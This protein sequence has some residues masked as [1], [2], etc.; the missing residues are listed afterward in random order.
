MPIDVVEITK[1]KRWLLRAAWREFGASSLFNGAWG[2]LAPE[3][4]A[5][6]LDV[7]YDDNQGQIKNVRRYVPLPAS[8]RRLVA[9]HGTTHAGLALDKLVYR[10]SGQEL[11][12]PSLHQVVEVNNG[13]ADDQKFLS[14]TYQPL[15]NRWRTVW[16]MNAAA[17]FT[18][19]TVGPLALHLSRASALENAGICLHPLYGFA[20]LPGS[21]LKGMARAYAETI[22]LPEQPDKNAAWRQIE[23]VFGWA[24]NPDRGKQLKDPS[25]PARPRP[26]NDADPRSPEI[27]SSS[28]QIIF[29]DAWP[30]AWPKLI[31]DIVNNH[32]S[33]YY[34]AKNDNGPGD[35]EGPIPVYFLAVSPGEQ[36]E[37]ALSKRRGDVSQP[38]LN[39][40]ESWLTG[41]LTQL[42]AGAKTAAG[43][44]AF[45]VAGTLRVPS[46][47]ASSKSPSTKS[48]EAT[49][50]VVTPAFLAGASQNA[51]D[52]DLRGATLRGLLRWWWRTM[53][54]G[55][56]DVATLRRLEA[57]VWGDTT[58]G[59]TIR[60]AVEPC[61]KRSPFERPGKKPGKDRHGKEIL[62]NDDDFLR[63]HAISTTTQGLFYAGYGTDELVPTGGKKRRKR[64]WCLGE[65]SKWI[66]RLTTK[67]NCISV[68]EHG[69]PVRCGVLP[70]TLI[71]DQCLAAL[72]LFCQYGGA[73]AKSRKGFGSFKSP[74]ELNDWDIERVRR[75]AEEFRAHWKIARLP[76]QSGA[77]GT[78]C[79]QAA[80]F[81]EQATSWTDSWF[82]I[83]NL[84]QWMQ[85]FAQAP[86]STGHGKH[87]AGKAA[88][89]LPRKIHGPLSGK[90]LKHQTNHQDPVPLRAP[91]GDRHASPVFYHF[92]RG[93]GGSLIFRAVIFHT[94]HLWDANKTAQ[95][96]REESQRVLKALA[97]HL[98]HELSKVAQAAGSTASS[99][100]P[101]LAPA[102]ATPS[103]WEKLDAVYIQRSGDGHLVRLLDGKKAKV[104]KGH[105]P[106]PL[107]KRDE[108]VHVYR[109]RSNARE[110]RWDLPSAR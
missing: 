49:L 73:G 18:A 2:K 61:G 24:P 21:G 74:P 10:Y 67:P 7:E 80:E 35:W 57:A 70:P 41:A 110:Y 46:A 60:L 59:S 4:V 54:A 53:H 43:Y 79:L 109:Q 93:A 99:T 63:K 66:L 26:V 76:F 42:G 15:F 107:P 37:F 17:H 32:H 78:A 72:W 48:F 34:G 23:D 103:D 84:G 83:D 47:A 92:A 13:L 106:V 3:D 85:S 62:I 81:I 95:L 56:V 28:G 64:R 11:S 75:V 91:H 102:A 45:K 1:D 98:K 105:I 87:C 39:L 44:G 22:W 50:E 14:D 89:G 65:G 8:T 25:H 71:L 96:G 100:T 12:K 68:E 55:H 27:R 9:K 33:D 19:T 16:S 20:Y 38:L 104:T 88:L 97:L 69:K 82:A 58:H 86:T 90:P 52:C 108:I 101:N 40:A 5:A 94:S 36:F 6:D 29:Y 51:A 77:N 31:V 30:V